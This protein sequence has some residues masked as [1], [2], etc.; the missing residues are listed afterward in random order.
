MLLFLMSFQLTPYKY[1]SQFSVSK[2]ATLALDL[3]LLDVPL[4]LAGL[5]W[6][7]D[8]DTRVWIINP[9]SLNLMIER[10]LVS[11]ER[12][13]TMK[14]LSELFKKSFTEVFLKCPV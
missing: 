1:H 6:E 2:G 9:S 5:A 10:D 13:L 7:C 3:C 12:N 8:F 14:D 11:T 4:R